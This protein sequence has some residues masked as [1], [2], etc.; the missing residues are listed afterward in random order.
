MGFQA[1]SLLAN[2]FFW[3][4]KVPEKNRNFIGQILMSEWARPTHPLATFYYKGCEK[5]KLFDLT[6]FISALLT[7][8]LIQQSSSRTRCLIIWF[9]LITAWFQ[10]AAQSQFRLK[11]S[12]ILGAEKMKLWQLQTSGYK[13]F[14]IKTLVSRE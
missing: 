3:K 5:Y 8:W 1:L 6:K 4:S 12:D 14:V 13:W 2:I 11:K 10:S 7:Y 9:Q